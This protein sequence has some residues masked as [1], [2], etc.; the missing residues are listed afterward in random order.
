MSPAGPMTATEVVE[1]AAHREAA[2]VRAVEALSERLGSQGD[3]AAARAL[4]ELLDLAER[5]AVALARTRSAFEALHARLH[6]HQ[7]ARVTAAGV[8]T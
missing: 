8:V 4:D 6:P 5:R 7:P 2:I 1:S 3:H